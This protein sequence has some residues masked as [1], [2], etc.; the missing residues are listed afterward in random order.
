MS[1][2]TDRARFL[3]A[4]I[5]Q[6]SEDTITEDS[7]ALD[8][9]D[10]FPLWNGNGVK[11]A[12]GYRVRY[13]SDLYKVLQEHTSQET[14][15]PVDVPSLFAKVLIP[16]PGVIPE[17]EQPGSTNGYSKG[18]KVTHNGKTWESQVDNNVWEPGATGTEALW[19]EVTE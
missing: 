18:D 2:I 8:Y 14:W 12:A 6:M 19:I 15:N 17:W 4:K 3:R 13:G 9:A 11:Y 7:E 10:L 16:D 1:E 5:E